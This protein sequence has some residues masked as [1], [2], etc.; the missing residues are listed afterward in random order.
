MSTKTKAID[1]TEYRSAKGIAAWWAKDG[2]WH[3]ALPCPEIVDG[4]RTGGF[5]WTAAQFNDRDAAIAAI[6]G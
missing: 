1:R 2:A 4:L 3:I 6:E 5:R